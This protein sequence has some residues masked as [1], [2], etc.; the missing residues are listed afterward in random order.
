MKN[1]V[2]PNQVHDLTKKLFVEKVLFEHL[3][4]QFVVHREVKTEIGVKEN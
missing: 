4:R 3:G 1:G 2:D